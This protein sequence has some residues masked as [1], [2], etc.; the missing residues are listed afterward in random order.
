MV[1]PSLLERVI[2]SGIDYDIRA[3][4]KLLIIAQCGLGLVDGLLREIVFLT[5]S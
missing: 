4:A 3:L 1:T 2:D 5:A